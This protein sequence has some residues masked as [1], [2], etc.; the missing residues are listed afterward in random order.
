[1]LHDKKARKDGTLIETVL[2]DDDGPMTTD[3]I[4]QR[5]TTSAMRKKKVM[6]TVE[7]D[8]HLPT[9]PRRLEAGHFE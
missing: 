8:S 2:I 4:F 5:M 1:M 3:F 6:R 9:L 7:Y